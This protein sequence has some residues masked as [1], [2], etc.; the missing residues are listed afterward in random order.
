MSR[1][2][3]LR[4]PPPP[5]TPEPSA[6]L[7]QCCALHPALGDGMAPA[8][9]PRPRQT[10]TEAI[11][12]DVMS[13][14]RLPD[15]AGWR[16][17]I[18]KSSGVG[19]YHGRPLHGQGT[20]RRLCPLATT[21]APFVFTCCRDS[22]PRATAV[23][24]RRNHPEIANSARP[25]MLLPFLPLTATRRTASSPR[26]LLRP[27]SAS[28]PKL[29]SLPAARPQPLE[30][31]AHQ[32]RMVCWSSANSSRR[33]TKRGCTASSAKRA[34][35]SS[36]SVPRTGLVI[37]FLARRAAHR[38]FAADITSHADPHCVGLSTSAVASPVSLSTQMA[39]PISGG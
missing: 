21:M 4:L 29:P 31:L 28:S 38:R 30:I 36:S 34:R 20:R 33:S 14:S 11:V 13:R 2:T 22:Q 19:E 26:H 18:A 7:K 25:A 3:R 8:R 1:I 6:A 9:L 35:T 10:L 12:L 15:E 27:S 23:E 24:W 37:P 16:S 5:H 32:G 17:A 39:R